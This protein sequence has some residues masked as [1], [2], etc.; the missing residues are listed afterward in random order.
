M[1]F[2]NYGYSR[3]QAAAE[4][5]RRYEEMYKMSEAQ[6]TDLALMLS[7][8]SDIPY[9]EWFNTLRTLQ[10]L[11]APANGSGNGGNGNGGNGNKSYET[12]LII[13]GGLLALL[14]IMRR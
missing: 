12:A 4:V 8:Q 13:G 11:P 1:A 6:I 14:F 3:E 2:V 10:R 9:W 5:A 7:R